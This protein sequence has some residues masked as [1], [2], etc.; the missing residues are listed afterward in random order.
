[1]KTTYC[2]KEVS[3]RFKATS[4]FFLGLALF[5][6]IG[7]YFFDDGTLG[8]FTSQP[9]WIEKPLIIFLIGL[10][11]SAMYSG[12]FIKEVLVNK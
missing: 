10:F 12:Q 6:F 7:M 11:I 4:S 5:T 9:L 3:V 8:D 2:F 1:M